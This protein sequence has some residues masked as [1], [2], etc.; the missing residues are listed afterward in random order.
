MLGH[1]RK[2]GG[3]VEGQVDGGKFDVD[4][5]VQQAGAAFRAFRAA[6]RHRAVRNEFRPGRTAADQGGRRRI[7]PCLLYTSRCV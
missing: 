5:R 1:A 3:M 2:T 6:L 4:D 7:L